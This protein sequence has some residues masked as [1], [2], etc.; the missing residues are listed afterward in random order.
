MTPEVEFS[1]PL[2]IDN[3]YYHGKVEPAKASSPANSAD[4]T[5]STSRHKGPQVVL[6]P[7]VKPSLA[8]TG[9][10]ATR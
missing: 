6:N 8:S 5:T 1:Q 4:K 10:A 2:S 9:L 7:Y 3:P